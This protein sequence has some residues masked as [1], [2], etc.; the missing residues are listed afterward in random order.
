MRVSVRPSVP[1]WI[2]YYSRQRK[3]KAKMNK[4]KLQ[5]PDDVNP[6]G[7]LTL[8]E[9]SKIS[10]VPVSMLYE[11]RRQ[12]WRG[13]KVY[14]LGRRVFVRAD[15]FTRFINANLQTA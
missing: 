2:G 12:P 5:L 13:M 10:G 15:E 4:P 14:K 6:G 8:N 11:W 1:Y 3:V 9:A 7:L